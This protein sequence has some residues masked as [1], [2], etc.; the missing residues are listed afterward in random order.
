MTDNYQPFWFDQAL[1]RERPA[2]PV[3]LT[4]DLD[5]DICIVGGGFTGLWSA[6]KL[7]QACPHS[8]ILLIE[9][10]RCGSGASGRN[11][12][13][14]LTWSTKYPTLRR[15]FGDTEARRLVQASEQA[16]WDI[17]DFCD[18]HEIDCELRPGGTLYTATSEAQRGSMTPL[19]A[20]LE[21]LGLNSWRSLTPAEV[22]RRAGS[23][24][25]L[26]GYFSPAAG[27]LQPGLLVRGLKAVAE[28]LGVEIHERTPMDRLIEGEPAEILTP[29]ARIRARQVV[30]ATNAWMA[31][32]FREFANSI[33]L[34]SSDMLITHPVPELLAESDLGNGCAVVDSRT[35]VHYY[36]ST[37]DGRLMLGKGGNLFAFGN[38]VLPAFDEP[39]RYQPML[40]NA[41]HRFFPTLDSDAIE[42]TWT[43]PSDRS[44]TGLP[45]FGHLRGRRNI[46]YG[47]GYSGNGVVQTWLGGEIIRSLLLGND[48]VWSRSGL[49]QGPRGY[50]PPEPLRWIG[51]MTVRQAI[52]RKEAAEDANRRPGRLDCRLA[53]LAAAAGKADK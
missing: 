45:F 6:I 37:P 28:S 7:R 26:E 34:V 27:S 41:L 23:A 4:Q 32:Q 2:A 9:A 40:R 10:D 1:Q 50:F 52:R 29:R 44:V 53:R 36:R 18:R 31:R 3:P 5:V 51:A 30:L 39:S 20:E 38:R 33:T 22:Q 48:D 13:C 12:G 25:H 35:F 14:M 43:G 21:R 16:V 8:R 24:A 46:V 47:F 42:R 11:G 19:V 49:A 17:A 15:L